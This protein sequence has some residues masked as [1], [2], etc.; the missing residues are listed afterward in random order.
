MKN[1][2]PEVVGAF[3]TKHI[4]KLAN[5]ILS[6]QEVDTFTLQLVSILNYIEHLNKADTN[7]V[8]ATYNVSPNKNETRKDTASVC[9][10][11]D[12]ALQNSTNTKNG[13]FVTKGVF[14]SE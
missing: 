10:T 7:S 9:L 11:Q 6:D 1:K 5:L 4:A 12:E 8:D 13:Q 2:K 3:D 14:K